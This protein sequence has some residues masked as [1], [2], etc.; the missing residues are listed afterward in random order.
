MNGKKI[1]NSNSLILELKRLEM[2][3][4]IQV[5]LNQGLDFSGLSRIFF[6]FNIKINSN[7]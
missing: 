1:G 5:K 7:Q 3:I 6:L 2:H 4:K